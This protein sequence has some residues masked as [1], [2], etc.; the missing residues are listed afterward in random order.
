MYNLLFKTGVVVNKPN[1]KKMFQYIVRN[2]YIFT[3]GK[4][5]S[6]INMYTLYYSIL[7]VF[8]YSKFRMLLRGDY[9]HLFLK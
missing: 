3:V 7:F 6:L 1:K 8:F 2:Y 5:Y 9:R 4:S